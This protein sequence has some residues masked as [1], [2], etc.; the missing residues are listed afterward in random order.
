MALTAGVA[1][2]FGATGPLVLSVQEYRPREGQI[3]M[4]A[5]VADVMQAGGMLVVEA[6]TGVGKTYAYLVPAL[7][8]GQRVLVSTATKAL[9]DQ[10]FG[11][12]IPHLRQVLGVSPRVALL[13]GRSSYLCLNRLESA[14]QDWRMDERSAMQ[15]LARIENW[16]HGTQSGDLAEVDALDETSPLLPL[17]TSTRENCLGARCPQ[18]ASC[19]VNRARRE[20]LAADVVVIN[21]HLFFADLNVRESGV[22]E[23]LPS[24]H[25]V[26]FDEAHQLNEIGVQFLG[27]QL[28]TGQLSNFARDLEQTT[29]E[30]AR[31]MAPWAALAAAVEGSAQDLRSRFPES[32]RI[33]RMD[34]LAAGARWQELLD[35]TGRALTDAQAA[36]ALVAEMAPELQ[37]LHGRASDLLELLS[38]F[39]QPVPDDAV[40]W[41]E[42]GRQ[43]RMLQSPL[44]VSVAMQTRVLPQACVE[45][46]NKSWVFTSATLGHDAGLSWMVDSCGLTGARIL[47][48]PSPFDYAQQAGLYIPKSFPKPGEAQHSFAVAALALE[49]AL[50]LGGRTLVLTTTLRA[51]RSIGDALALGLQ[52]R[53]D[54]EV[55]VQGAMPKRELLAR[56]LQGGAHGRGAVLVASA[57]FWEGID[58]PG[59]ALQLL[60]IDKLPFTPP[61]DPVLQARSKALEGQGKSPFKH[62]H[63][64]QAAVALRQG[65]GRLIR[66][67]SDQGVL[68]VCD[69][70][71]N[72]MGYGRQL[73]A[74]LPP[75]RRL[76]EPL[77]FLATLES[78]TRASTTDHSSSSLPW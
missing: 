21:H 72:Q 26:V 3:Q 68:V 64:P 60:V 28:G 34:W 53:D 77:D 32:E 50:V 52:G 13:K 18:A 22:A 31:G 29:Q 16:A 39:L 11:R 65:A 78:F 56:F 14:R 10:L 58:M 44:D 6:G 40:R 69:V 8:S 66:R 15:H 73:V 4:A 5:A 76:L 70:R 46:G 71:L 42:L 61:D 33:E 12:D 17:V 27:R 51:M 9:Q 59:E 48:V 36:L 37:M 7:L 54:L 25:A 49:G 41:L 2:A 38:L 35:A 45:G 74:A 24:V 55:L 30:H 43:V 63:L 75:M 23:L 20:A 1:A 62:L 19:F 57:T 47:K 67:E